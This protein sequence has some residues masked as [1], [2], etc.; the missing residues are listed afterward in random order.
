MTKRLAPPKILCKNNPIRRKP[1]Q[2]TKE[3]IYLVIT[4]AP[5]GQ[6]RYVRVNVITVAGPRGN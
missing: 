1:A 2:Q 3:S 5:V 4:F 6:I